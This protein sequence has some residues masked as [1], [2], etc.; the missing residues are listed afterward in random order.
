MMGLKWGRASTT[1]DGVQAFEQEAFVD[2]SLTFED[3]GI[4]ATMNN[5]V[6]IP[7]NSCLT[8]KFGVTSTD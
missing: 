5:L 6:G 1:D 4:E 3:G 2:V 8:S 7:S